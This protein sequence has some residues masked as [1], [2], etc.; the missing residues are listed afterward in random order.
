MKR[1]IISVIL[2]SSMILSFAGCKKKE[3]TESS[4]E[5]T[6]TSSEAAVSES[7]TEPSASE[8]VTEPE[9]F[10]FNQTNIP[11]IQFCYSTNPMAV[12]AFSVLLGVSRQEAQELLAQKHYDI[13]Y[14]SD[15]SGIALL[16][17]TALD[18]DVE[19]ETV[20]Y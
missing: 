13:R 18:A 17:E 6:T 2:V 20:A 9:E 11:G 5:E 3:K 14:T 10:A 15:Q 16:P 4:S 1:R 8:T 19:K 12:S 7:E